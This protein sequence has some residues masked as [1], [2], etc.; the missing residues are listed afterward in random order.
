MVD[1][2]E[3]ILQNAFTTE[4]IR[5]FMMKLDRG[6]QT[7]RLLRL[8]TALCSCQITPIPENQWDIMQVMLKENNIRDK[9]LMPLRQLNKRSEIEVCRSL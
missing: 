1:H 8:L 9:F 5:D 6:M 2:N 4:I 7:P 3:K